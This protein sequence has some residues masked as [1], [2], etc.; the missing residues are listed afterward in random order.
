[1]TYWS[2][3]QLLAH[4]GG[5]WQGWRRGSPLTALGLQALG[6]PT[7]HFDEKEEEEEEANTDEI[8]AHYALTTVHFGNWT[9]FA[10]SVATG[11]GTK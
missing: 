10:V 4:D 1:M 11:L 5:L 2:C 8:H 3:G 6:L 9:G 7:G